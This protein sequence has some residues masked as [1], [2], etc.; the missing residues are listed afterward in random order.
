MSHL[1]D[2]LKYCGNPP[3]KVSL[4]TYNR[5][6]KYRHQQSFSST[7]TSF[8][9][10]L[11]NQPSNGIKRTSDALRNTSKNHQKRTQTEKARETHLQNASSQPRSL[12]RSSGDLPETGVP[13]DRAL[14][15]SDGTDNVSGSGIIDSS[16][17]GA[18]TGEEG[19]SGI[20]DVGSLEDQ[21]GMCCTLYLAYI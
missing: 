3:K 16:E 1:C 15:P 8:L 9:A 18:G 20:P 11:P 6:A 10:R 12:S 17:T 2:C 19:D 21:Q 7:F 13:S 5:H 4:A 14:S